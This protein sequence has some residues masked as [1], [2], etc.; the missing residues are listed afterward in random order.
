MRNAFRSLAVVVA[1]GILI[2]GGHGDAQEPCVFQVEPSSARRPAQ[3]V[4]RESTTLQVRILTQTDS[5]VDVVAIDLSGLILASSDNGYSYHSDGPLA[6]EVRNRSDRTL[7]YVS[8][9]VLVGTCRL[10]G[11]QGSL[12]RPRRLALAP[13]AVAHLEIPL[14]GGGGVLSAPSD[15]EVFV[16]I[17]SVEFGSCVYRPA[18][19]F[20]CQGQ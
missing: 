6:V 3:I 18:M 20:Q 17:S 13:G 2:S 15:L 1:G 4:R 16:W 12:V 5:P 19:A 7:N 10:V 9:S 14:G 11:G 8:V